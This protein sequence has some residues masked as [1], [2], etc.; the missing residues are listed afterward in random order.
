MRELRTLADSD[1]ELPRKLALAARRSSPSES[2]DSAADELEQLLSRLLERG[3]R[4]R[5][6]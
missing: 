6:T 4:V 1:R 3:T 5:G 2:Y